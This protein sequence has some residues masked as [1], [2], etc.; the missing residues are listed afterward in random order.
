MVVGWG[1][2]GGLGWWLGGEFMGG[3]VEV[4][5]LGSSS[6]INVLIIH[7][8]INSPPNLGRWRWCTMEG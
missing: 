4:W 5:G 8:P 3:C 6:F 2:Y 1:V 7:Q